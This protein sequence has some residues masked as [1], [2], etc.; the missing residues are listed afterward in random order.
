MLGQIKCG[1]YYYMIHII[2]YKEGDL[3]V[4]RMHRQIKMWSLLL[5]II[6]Q[7]RDLARD[8]NVDNQVMVSIIK[9]HKLNPLLT[10]VYDGSFNLVRHE[11]ALIGC[12][13]MVA[14]EENHR[15]PTPLGVYMTLYLYGNR[16]WGER[17]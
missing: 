10:R 3:G 8:K 4:I 17:D 9:Q 16:G 1:G 14:G 5:K 12:W 15:V 11:D 6:L 7:K 13:V 2:S